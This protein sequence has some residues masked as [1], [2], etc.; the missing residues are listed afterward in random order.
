M[1]PRC[2]IF[3]F[4]FTLCSQKYF[5][6]LG[7]QWEPRID[8]LLF[9]PETL[10][11]WAEPWMAGQKTTR[12]V[13]E[14]LAG[15]LPFSAAELERA[16]EAGCRELTFNPGVW[17]LARRL[18]SERV[19]SALVTV[20][21]DCFTQIVSPSHRL[22]EVFDVIVNSADH[23][24]LH[25]RDLWPVAFAAL[26]DGLDYAESLLLDDAVANVEAFRRLGGDAILYTGDAD[27]PAALT[28]RGL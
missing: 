9:G 18:K 17:D 14:H 26:G 24:T 20:N 23:G 4:A 8:A 27:L 12:Q 28:R 11:D 7:P 5:H 22:G 15:H 21:M 1:P 10:G 3:D 19:P 13:C 2:V 25:K 6:R 16:L